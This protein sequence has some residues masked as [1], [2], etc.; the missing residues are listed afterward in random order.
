MKTDTP[1]NFKNFIK[2]KIKSNTC[3]RSHVNKN[4]N[5]N[6]I[7]KHFRQKLCS[8]KTRNGVLVYQDFKLF[9]GRMI[10]E[11]PWGSP[12]RRV[13]PILP[14]EKVGQ[15]VIDTKC[16]NPL[17]PRVTHEASSLGLLFYSK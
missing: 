5:Y 7:I 8:Q 16:S 17:Q 15:S 2:C 4:K 12:L 6:R 10:L 1:E 14:T 3:T 9:W 11:P 13:I